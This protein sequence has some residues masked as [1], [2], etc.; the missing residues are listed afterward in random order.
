MAIKSA[1]ALTGSVRTLLSGMMFLEFFIWGSWYVTMGTYLATVL[2]ADGLQIGTAYSALAIATIISPFFVGMVADRFFSAQKLL[3]VLHLAGAAILFY[4]IKVQNASQFYWI[5]LLYSLLYAPTL[6]LSNSVAFG[7]MKDATKSFAGIRVFGTIGW[8]V[9]GLMIDKV[10]HI[11]PEEMAFTFKMAAVASLVLGVISF[12]LPNTPPKAK[13]QK[14]T[15]GQILGSDAFVLFKDRSFNV[16]FISSILIC[17]PLSFYYSET[18][19]FLIEAGMK[20]A[21]SNMTLGQ[22]SEGVF[23]LLIPLFF[24]KLG[25]KWMI[26]IGMIAWILRFL[27]FGY[28]D[29]DGYLWMLFAGIILH[30]VCFDF[31]FVT[32][33]IYTNSK[34]G[35]S[36]KSS[37]QGMITMATYGIGMWIGTKLSGYVAKYYTNEQNVHNWKA[38]WMV[39][40]VIAFAVLILF[41]L[42]FSEKNKNIPIAETQQNTNLPTEFP[43]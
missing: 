4:I 24:R 25:V 30:G 28:G 26:A 36:I 33:Q 40:A 11:T 32:G 18:N 29:A 21:T 17:I 31:F 6:A 5:I 43:A 15:I 7:Q 37:A 42:F 34:A 2:H 35:E 8:I 19:Q 10:F 27:C 22:I 41:T 12:I 3:G 38:I 39:P 16:F 1:K 9:A 20:N 13:G 14:A 23:I